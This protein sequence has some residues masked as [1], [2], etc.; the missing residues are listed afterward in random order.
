MPKIDVSG[1]AD[2][3]L[4]RLLNSLQ[5]D[6]RLDATGLDLT[7]KVLDGA[8]LAGAYLRGC[9][10]DRAS[11]R[12]VVLTSFGHLGHCSALG[13]DLSGAT[14]ASSLMQGCDLRSARLSGASLV[15]AQVESVDLRGCDMSGADLTGCLAVD[16]DLRGTVLT[17][18]RLRSTRLLNC[19]LSGAD[20]SGVAGT[21]IHASIDVGTGSRHRMVEGDSALAWLREAG[22][23][24]RWCPPERDQDTPGVQTTAAEVA[25]LSDVDL[26]DLLERR[27]R[28]GS[29][30]GLGLAGRRLDGIL[31]TGASLH[32]CDFDGAHMHFADLYASYPARCSFV[33]TDLSFASLVKADVT[34]CDLRD[35]RLHSANLVRVRLSGS[36]MR[37]ADLSHA[38]LNAGFVTETDLRGARL[39]GVLFRQTLLEGS[40]LD[41][42][43]LSG[44]RG[45][46]RR[47][48]INVGTPERPRLIDGPDA[49]AWLRAA[50]AEVEWFLP[51]PPHRTNWSGGG[52]GEAT[53][54]RLR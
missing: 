51:D 46:V 17:G 5:D 29:A 39:R 6:S 44:A 9:R 12:G 45:T 33:G 28:D 4:A 20:L 19:R 49:L 41:G 3:D 52:P 32:D 37:G 34:A 43:D 11:L 10:L 27:H 7:G 25:A 53:L 36:D 47:A 18:A 23:D 54:P 38:D 16:S 2:R 40:L 31:L 30:T 42:A 21:L 24:V 22:A 8:N 26:A 35:A 15:R 13:A 50:G 48:P 1:L 14:L